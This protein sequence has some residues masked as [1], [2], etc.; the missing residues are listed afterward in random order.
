MQQQRDGWMWKRLRGEGS[1]DSEHC[2][3]MKTGGRL[4]MEKFLRTHL[5]V[6]VGSGREAMDARVKP[7]LCVSDESCRLRHRSASVVSVRPDERFSP[8]QPAAG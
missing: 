6:R 3:L 7:R 5:F 2:G 8:A 4:K 1:A